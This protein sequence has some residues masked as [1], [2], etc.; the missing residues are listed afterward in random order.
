MN[1]LTHLIPTR[2][3]VGDDGTDNV[4]LGFELPDGQRMTFLLTV[5]NAS[6]ILADF[7]AAIEKAKAA[8]EHKH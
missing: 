6:K 2:F 8:R 5:E 3:L 1:E 4:V 7:P